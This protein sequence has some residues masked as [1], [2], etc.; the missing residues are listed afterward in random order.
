MG[1]SEVGSEVFSEV[2]Q[3]G[4]DLVSTGPDFLAPQPSSIGMIA[5]DS[6][7]LKWSSPSTINFVIG[8]VSF[9][10]SHLGGI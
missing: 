6:V 10:A 8:L 4:L 2:Q 5:P 9:G 1:L 7:K 3:D